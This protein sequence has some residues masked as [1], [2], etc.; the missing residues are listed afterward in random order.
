MASPPVSHAVDASILE[1]FAYISETP[2]KDV[3]GAL[4]DA[5]GL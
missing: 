5:F 4:I 1:P 2:G 3:R